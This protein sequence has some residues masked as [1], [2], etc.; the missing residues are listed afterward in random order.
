[1]KKDRFVFNNLI[2]RLPS[3]QILLMNMISFRRMVITEQQLDD[4]RT[5]ETLLSG[6]DNLPEALNKLY[7]D[8]VK[9]K[10]ILS[11]ETIK[12]A[13]ALLYKDF[14]EKICQV[15]PKITEATFNLTHQC[16]FSCD[17][18]YQNA[19]KHKPHY[20]GYMKKK[21]I[22]QLMQ[23]LDSSGIYFNGFD[24]IVISGGEPLLPQLVDTI[25]YIIDT[26]QTKQR[27][28]F[29]NGMNILEL[30]NKINFNLIDEFQI[31][32]DGPD[33]VLSSVNHGY[34]KTQTILDGIDYLLSLGKMVSI[35]IIWTS[36][37]ANNLHEFVNVINNRGY[38]NN[39]KCTVK[40]SV[41]NDYANG[42]IIRHDMYHW[43]GLITD[44]INNHSLLR[45]INTNFTLNSELKLLAEAI[46][47]SLNEQFRHRVQRCNPKDSLPL[48]FEPNGEIHWCLCLGNSSGVVGNYKTGEWDKHRISGLMKRNVFSVDECRGC[49]M[50]YVCGGGCPLPKM[51]IGLEGEN[52][53]VC[54]IFEDEFFWNNLE[55]F[56]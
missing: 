11:E 27:M 4:L 34:G 55:R 24:R 25:N 3:G 1:M 50:R 39:P 16:N 41:A 10:Q 51:G 35:S 43:E 22:D 15:T 54:G 31:S 5:I 26:V 49:P 38:N 14:E 2:Y 13:D 8:L 21:E 9:E 20:S 28:L 56:V 47:R 36:E 52:T 33:N 48:V 6:G 19:Y 18:C 7:A 42:K 45:E 53:P 12:K 46:H 23:F 44:N 40:T 29:S 17:Y 32:L 30:K 37:L